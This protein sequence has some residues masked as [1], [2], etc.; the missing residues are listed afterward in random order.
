MTLYVENTDLIGAG[1]QR[2]LVIQDQM[3]VMA[4]VVVARTDAAAFTDTAISGSSSNNLIEIYG[5]V[6]AGGT[7]ISLGNSLAGDSNHEVVVK[8]GGLVRQTLFANGAAI[9]ITAFASTVVNEGTIEAEGIGIW[10]GGSPAIANNDT[11]VVNSGTIVADVDGIQR[12]GGSTGSIKVTNTGTIVGGVASYDGT[13]STAF[14][15]II[16]DGRMEG[17]ILLGDGIDQY[18]GFGGIVIGTVFGGGGT[19]SFNGGPNDDRFDG[20][21]GADGMSGNGGNDTYTVDASDSV[22]ETA[23]NGTDRII[24]AVSLI[25]PKNVEN[26]TLTGSLSTINTGNAGANSMFGNDGANKLFGL[27]GKDALR[28]N[29]GADQLT[30]GAGADELHGGADGDRFVFNSAAESRAAGGIDTI[31]DFSRVQ[32]DKIQLNAIDAKTTVAGNN[33]FTFIGT[34]AFSGAAGE[35]RFQKIGTD[36]RITADTNGDKKIDM[37]IISDIAFN[38]IKADFIL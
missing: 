4:G 10:L 20:G 15:F 23:N 1:I 6:F 12:N 18:W 36:T 17:D 24:T 8:E 35:L 14:D 26:L 13:G 33:V 25:L 11:F 7:A 22:F 27:S 9:R 21:A 32:G 29:A 34:K 2:S 5:S 38:F 3:I 37:T 28:G 19:D 31:M 16:N 30:G